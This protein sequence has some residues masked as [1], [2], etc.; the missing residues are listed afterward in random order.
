MVGLL[1]LHLLAVGVWA[2]CV[3]IDVAFAR[4]LPND[5]ASLAATAR[6]HRVVDLAIE[7]PA[8]LVAAVTG[9]ALLS[10]V[11][12][13]P[14]LVLKAVAGGIA[15]S[16]NLLG[17]FIASQRARA[18]EHGEHTALAAEDGLQQTLR[19]LVVGG[20]AVAVTSGIVHALS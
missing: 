18:T 13:T 2:A 5:G 14:L 3:A 6:L 10:T 19:S 4:I 17:T 7:A 12:W 20:M 16:A 15:I 9:A 1:V 11:S 8:V